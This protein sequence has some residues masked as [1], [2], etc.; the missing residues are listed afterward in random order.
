MIDANLRAK[1]QEFVQENKEAIIQDIKDLVA[2]KSVAGQPGEGM[3]FGPGPRAAL[4]KALEMADRF[5][6]KTVNVDNY[7]GYAELPGESEDYLATV[8]HLDVVPEGNGWKADPFTVREIDGWLLGRGVCDN[9]GASVLTMY[10]LKFF[11]EQG[12]KLRYTTRAIWGTDEETG[13]SDVHYYQQKEKAPLF[14]FSPDANFPVCCGEKGIVSFKL[15][16]KKVENSNV[17]K[18]DAGMAG[19]V[20]PDLAEVTFKKGIGSFPAGE[21]LEIVETEDGVKV[22]AH[23]IGGHAAFPAGTKNAIGMLV[24]Y[25]LE[26]NLFSEEEK[27][28]FELLNKLHSVTDGSGLGIDADDGYFEPLTCIGGI[29]AYEDGVFS[30]HINI[31]Y[32][33]NTDPDKM[34]SI[35]AP[36]FEA[37]GGHVPTAKGSKPMFIDPE[38]PIIRAMQDTYNEITGLD[39]KPYTIGGGTYARSFPLGVAFGIEPKGDELPDFVG[40][41]HM[42]EEGYSIDGFMS[43]LE[44]IILSMY[45]LHKLDY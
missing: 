10:M 42:A 44:I 43:A 34:H 8:C 12:M 39:T 11:K 35:L 22:I 32:P 6:L 18:F 26:N 7:I 28:Y 27:P 19:N 25:G 45:E 33:T 4:D 15:F 21:G 14:I 3:P 29:M 23:G 36:Q 17:V 40:T 38:T 1:V 31:R 5:G 41:A 2:I 30:Q 9:K 37:I 13:S 20:I 16:S 24:A